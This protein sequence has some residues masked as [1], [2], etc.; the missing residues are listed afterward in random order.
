MAQVHDI[1]GTT[2]NYITQAIWQ[3][4]VNSQSLNLISVH[5]KWRNHTWL[6]GVMT[7]TEWAT[8]RG[9][10]GSVVSITTTDPDDPNGDY[11]TY[12]DAIVKDVSQGSH[13]SLNFTGVRIEFLVNVS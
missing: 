5:N 9:K 4:P 7:A 3:Q 2:V 12:Y 13:D 10:R 11:I 1:D 6:S 8:F